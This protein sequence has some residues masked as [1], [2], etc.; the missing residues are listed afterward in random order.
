MRTL[1]PIALA[2]A[3]TVPAFLLRLGGLVLPVELAT[4]GFGLSVVGAAFI[5]SWS[6]EAA[7]R[8]IPRA[9]ALTAVALL[10]VLPEYAVDIIFAFKAG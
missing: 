5:M 8:D 7:E 6:A 1:L 3:V 9:L 4:L 2:L 10:A